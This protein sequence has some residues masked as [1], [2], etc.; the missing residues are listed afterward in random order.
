MHRELLCT[1]GPSSLNDGVIT[2]LA[3]LG[4]HLFRLNLSH[5]SASEVASVIEYVQN[6]NSLAM[7]RL[8]DLGAVLDFLPWFP[9]GL[10]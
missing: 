9:G 4:V 7:L 5:T 3:D 1:L 2:R 10:G 8:A 6:G